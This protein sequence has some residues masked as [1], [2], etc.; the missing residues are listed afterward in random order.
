MSTSRYSSIFP[1]EGRR[2]MYLELYQTLLF[3][4]RNNDSYNFETDDGPFILLGNNYQMTNFLT[5]NEQLRD[6]RLLMAPTDGSVITDIGENTYIIL[7]SY[8]P[9]TDSS[10]KLNLTP[11]PLLF[12]I[13]QPILSYTEYLRTFLK[14]HCIGTQN[15]LDCI[16]HRNV[17]FSDSFTHYTHETI[18][19]ILKIEPLRN[20][21][22]YDIYI[23]GNESEDFFKLGYNFKQSLIKVFTY[24][25][26]DDTI[27]SLYNYTLEDAKKSVCFED[28]IKCKYN[29]ENFH[30]FS[31]YSQE[32][33]LKKGL[34]FKSEPWII[35]FLAISAIGSLISLIIV[36]F[37]CVYICRKDILEGNPLTTIF[38]LLTVLLMYC[39]VLLFSIQRNPYN[40]DLLCLLQSLW[41]TLSISGAFSLIL[42]RSILLSTVTR[43]IAYMSHIPGSVQSFLA[44]FIFGVQA[45]LSLQILGN[46]S[47]VF[48]GNSFLYLM[49]YNM[50]LLLFIICLSPMVYKSQRNYKEGKYFVISAVL[51]TLCWCFWISC[52]KVLDDS[53]KDLLICFAMVSTASILQGTIFISRTYLMIV[54]STRNKLRN[55]LPKLNERNGVLDVY[56]ADERNVYDCVNVAAINAISVARPGINVLQMDEDIY[57]YP[58]LPR[59]EEF[60][61][62]IQTNSSNHSDKV[63][64]F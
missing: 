6:F 43:E 5:N 44:L 61:F 31:N 28:A 49:S 59:D 52:Y 42:S 18:L 13:A 36:A 16:K 38:L 56:R 19:K 17:K 29:C 47:K 46:C 26:F 3:Q 20:N 22:V 37:L 40:E 24:N 1:R 14:I 21:F 32:N 55:N 25:I 53:W 58:T 35:V 2:K 30:E 41:T 12:E 11:T 48:E 10:E 64:R 15:K 60:N 23:T 34:Q 39:S 45:A 4:R 63:T 9:L 8:I 50:M 7:P 33:I 27:S 54:S 57:N 51:I 62:D